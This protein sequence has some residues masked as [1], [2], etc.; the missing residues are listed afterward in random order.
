MEYLLGQVDGR[1]E[2]IC[3][4]LKGINGRLDKI[5]NTMDCKTKDCLACRKEIDAQIAPFKGE[6]TGAQAVSRFI[7]TTFGKISLLIGMCGG[8]LGIIVTAWKVYD[9][10]HFG[11]L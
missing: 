3:L 5:D 8:V 4:E 1:L 10:L 6:Q 11:R 9:L 2:G 7:D